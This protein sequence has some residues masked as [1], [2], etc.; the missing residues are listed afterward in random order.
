MYH[1]IIRINDHKMQFKNADKLT[2][3]LCG[4]KVSVYFTIM[5]CSACYEFISY[6]FKIK[7]L[8]GYNYCNLLTSTNKALLKQFK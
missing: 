7:K 3:A 8:F 5:N 6:C 4:K 2:I 1:D